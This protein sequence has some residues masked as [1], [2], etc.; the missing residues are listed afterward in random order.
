MARLLEIARRSFE[1]NIRILGSKRVIVAGANQFGSVWTRD[2]CFASGG[3]LKAGLPDVVR[4]TLAAICAGQRAD[5]LMPRLLDSSDPIVRFV[6]SALGSRL[7]LSEPLKPNFISDHFVISIDSNA[8]LAW[9]ARR[10]ADATGDTAFLESLRPRLERGL[11]WYRTVEKDG[12]A[13]QPPFSDWKDSIAARRDAVFMM[14]LLRWQGLRALGRETEALAVKTRADEAFWEETGG[15]YRDTLGFPLFSSDSNFGAIAWGFCSVERARRIW[16]AA[17]RLGLWTRWGPRAGQRYPWREK[18]VL[19]RIALMH[20][21]H[22]DHVWLWNSAVALTALRRLGENAEAEKL[23]AEITALAERDGEI[24]E[25]YEPE[26]GR[27]A[28]TWLYQSEAPFTW[29]SAM[30]FEALA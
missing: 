8:L 15:F 18:G 4:D 11:D 6:R 23:A 28:K 14:E 19:P 22:D 26:D 25:V 2:F 17:R 16:D 13:R 9:T 3:L 21:Y 12:L 24:G 29:S 20:R 5:G 7:P 10:Y 27:P 1:A 30:L